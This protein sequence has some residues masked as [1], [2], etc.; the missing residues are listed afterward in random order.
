M[1]TAEVKAPVIDRELIEKYTLRGP[2]YTSYPTAPEWTVDV[3]EEEYRKHIAETNRDSSNPLALY[4]HIPFCAERCYYCAC[5]VIITP[6]KQVSDNYVQYLKRE[7]DMVARDINPERQVIQFHLG[8]GTPTHLTPE[9]LDELLSYTA[10]RFSIATDAE[11]SIEVDPR[12]TSVEQLDVLAK[13]KFNRI[14]FGVEDFFK[15]TQEAIN[16]IQDIQQTKDLVIHSRERGFQSVNIDLVYGLPHQT[17]TTFEHTAD[18]ICDIDPDRLA[19]YNY[20]HLPSKVPHQRHIEEDWL[21]SPE[22][23]FNI[24]KLAV[25]RFSDHG[26]EYIGMDHFAKPDDELTLALKQGT[27]QRNFMGFTTKAGTDLY[28]FGTSA[29][30]S[31]S[32][33]YIQNVKNLRQYKKAIDEG[34]LPIERGM[35]LS[36][37]DRIRRWVIMELMCNLKVDTNRFSETWHYDFHEYFKDVIPQLKPF[38]ID[39]LIEPNI[40]SSIQVTELG[41]IIVRPVAMAFDY[42]LQKAKQERQ[43]KVTYSKTL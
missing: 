8:G 19:L 5:N 20:A 33:L 37:D 15:K 10:E 27:L 9:S 38:I 40:A 14:S 17:T 29:I 34:H 4:M 43:E 22:T 7:M 2:R 35:E 3:G 13:H 25:Q 39:G 36:E 41:Q 26:Y 18:I 31:L 1:N 6:H 32:S 12:V 23:R 21:P 24:F 30:T 16:R 28:S 42:Y 11:L